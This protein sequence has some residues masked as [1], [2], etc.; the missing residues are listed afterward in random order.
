MME[1]YRRKP[2]G[3]SQSKAPATA[4]SIC[5]DCRNAVPGAEAG[6]DWSERGKPVPGWDATRRDVMSGNGRGISRTESY[7]VRGCPEFVRG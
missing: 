6:C 2:P 7:L 3:K 4:P 1:R 5:W